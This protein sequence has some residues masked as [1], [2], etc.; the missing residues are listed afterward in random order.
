MEKRTT[1]GV[2]SVTPK[3]LVDAWLCVC[4]PR[5]RPQDLGSIWGC[6]A[7]ILYGQLL[8]EMEADGC[9]EKIVMRSI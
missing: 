7:Y 9:G 4:K 8:I 5:L 3:G 1:Q 2:A 6:K